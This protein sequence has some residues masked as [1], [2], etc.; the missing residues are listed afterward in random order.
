MFKYTAK[1]YPSGNENIARKC[2]NPR[3]GG[4]FYIRYGA[5][6]YKCPHCDW[7]Q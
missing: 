7:A 5:Q 6:N 2:T 4:T 1:S 3:C